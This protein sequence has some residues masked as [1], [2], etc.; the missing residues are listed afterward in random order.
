MTRRMGGSAAAV[1]AVGAALAAARALTPAPT[2]SGNEHPAVVAPPAASR[3][4]VS[5]APP[6]SAESVAA[7]AYVGITLRAQPAPEFFP[8]SEWVNGG[9]LKLADLRGRVVI[10]HFWTNGCINCIHNYP[11]YRSWQAKYDAKKV[12]IIGVHTPEF[13]WE[14]AAKRVK[15]KAEE[16][17]LKFPIVLD[18]EGKAWRAWGN[19]YWPTVYLVDR[20]GQVRYGWEGELHLDT[21]EGKHFAAHL[22]EL[23][24]E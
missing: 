8:G 12:T 23:L 16:N 9:P 1:L 6:A 7:D 18:P 20:K 19:R 3:N 2:D 21:A 4:E 14:A 24:A 13:D 17:G 22:D 10:L 5:Q 15:A 11:A